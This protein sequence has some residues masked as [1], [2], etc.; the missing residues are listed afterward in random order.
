MKAISPNKCFGAAS[1][2]WWGGLT[3]NLGGKRAGCVIVGIS[4]TI[5]TFFLDVK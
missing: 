5:V 2:P 1:A 4:P 3:L